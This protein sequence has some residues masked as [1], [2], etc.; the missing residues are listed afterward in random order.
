MEP[1]RDQDLGRDNF[2]DN[3]IP[4][5]WQRDSQKDLR[6]GAYDKAPLNEDSHSRHDEDNEDEELEEDITGPG[7]LPFRSRR[8]DLV[9]E[10]TEFADPL[11]SPPPAPS[12]AAF[13]YDA[14]SLPATVSD[15]RGFGAQPSPLS[16]KDTERLIIQN[17]PKFKLWT[18]RIL[19]K[20]SLLLFAAVFLLLLLVTGLV[21]HLSLRSKGLAVANEASHYLG[22]CLP[23]TLFVF[24][25]VCWRQVDY[26]IKSLMPWSEMS[27]FP[28][29]AERSVF[30]DYLTPALPVSF[31]RA[32][33]N[34]HWPVVL[35]SL[36][37]T[38]L[39]GTMLFSTGL[40][41]LEDA[42]VSEIRN[43]I[44]L[45]SEFKLAS[46][47]DS[48]FWNVGPGGAQLYNAVNF[49]GLHYPPGTSKDAL[50]PQLQIPANSAGNTNFSVS[51][52]AMMFDLDCQQLPITN[53]T[54]T[55]I[56]WKSMLAQY[57]VADVN[58]TDCSIKGIPLAG[59]PD[60]YQY[61]DKNAT[62]NYQ[63]Q[64]EVYPCNTGWDF[65][66]AEAKPDDDKAAIVFDPSADQRVFLSVTNLEISP[67]DKS[68]NAPSYM[69][70]NEISAF[71]CKPSYTMRPV[72]ASQPSPVDGA[73][74]FRSM[75]ESGSAPVARI[76]T[77]ADNERVEGISNGAVAMAVHASASSMFLGTGGKDFAL[78]EMVPTFFQFM[79][80]KAKKDGIGA[81]TDPELLKATAKNVYQGMA[82]QTMHLLARQ[83]A[84]K[85]T[86]G[87]IEYAGQKLVAYLVSTA[88]I[89][90][91]LGMCA[92]MAAILAFIA[93][94]AV[95]PSR[96]GSIASMTN[97]MATSPLFRQVML[98]TGKASTSALRQ[99]LEECRYKTVLTSTPSSF[100]LEAVRQMETETVRNDRKA[101]S[102]AAWWRP[103]AAHWWFLVLA[104]AIPLAMIG[105]LEGIQR[106][107]DSNQGFLSVSRSSA[108][109]FTTFIPAAAVVCIASTYAK[110]STMAAVFAPFLALKK[111]HA[112]A[113]RTMHFDVVGRTHPVAFLR[114]IKARHFAV[115]ILAA[116]SMI[117]LL[118]AIVVSSLYSVVE[119]DRS[120]SM[121]I[122]RIDNFKLDNA[123]LTMQDNHAASMDS[124]IRYAGVNYSQ[125]TWE[126]LAFP[127]Y[128]QKQF[129]SD[130]FLGDAPL[131]AKVQAI[132]PRLTCSAV[133]STGRVISQVADKQSPGAYVKLP[134]QNEYW[135]PRPGHVTV[136]FNTTLKFADYCETPP[137]TNVSQ[138]SWMQ[139]F[140]VPNDTNTAYIGKGSVLVWDGK[141]IY[142]DGAV[143]THL[144]SHV[145]VNF[146][147]QDHGCPSFAATFGTIKTV[148]SGQG[149]D[150]S[151]WKFE[152]DLATVICYQ[153][154]EE[155]T[156]DVTWQ[157]PDL[158]L[159]PSHPPIIDESSARKLNSSTGSERFQ[160]PVNAWLEGL[161]DPVYDRRIPA[162]NNGT[163]ALNDVDELIDALILGQPGVPITDIVGE[164]NARRLG[165]VL[166][167]AYQAYMAQA[168]S[169]NMRSSTES[170]S[171]RAVTGSI[172]GTMRIPDQRR[173]VQNAAPKIALQVL[174]AIMVLCLAAARP[175]LRV[176]RV[177]PHNPRTIAG[178][179]ALLADSDLAT[180]KVIPAGSEWLG[181]DALHSAKVLSGWTFALRWWEDAEKTAEARRYGVGIEMDLS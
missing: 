143:N 122:Q 47:A 51:V 153:T 56:S 11:A 177:L 108:T 37:Y 96:P 107:S 140:S 114:S 130:Q 4:S 165:D 71:L 181:D 85:S 79:T 33:R 23:T 81:F 73:A 28:A 70:V 38:L 141:E 57:F 131:V 19:T 138:A 102:T 150:V 21:Y 148:Q 78:S 161:T 29:L 123:K 133:P 69:Y 104:L 9:P 31:Y 99:K 157:L 159:D 101:R 42:S 68:L 106:L 30:V 132:R 80:M 166:T 17:G 13:H 125:W 74:Q 72:L 180:D 49:Q 24:I 156:A 126:G 151:S 116:A 88:M 10:E 2:H 144:S 53:A 179:A 89:C 5:S 18:P 34:R 75:A 26:H 152:H 160:I 103:T 168:V 35:S 135:T 63:A 154:F 8:Y 145:S 76:E 1:T 163:S 176:G 117:A 50:I 109:I 86:V 142:G 98:G 127:R 60:H 136:G 118:L 77:G 105:A 155:V 59:G 15:R 61:N 164:S 110:L 52:D 170:I 36:V 173:L 45:K 97:I 54:K 82:A 178:M 115:A 146:D 128:E 55:S 134:Y 90:T 167:R 27:R 67:Y 62:Q 113:H 87:S 41:M 32:V 139:Y 20:L 3:L 44:K 91:F 129:P 100:S 65:S 119:F 112:A 84:E 162:P 158:T 66:K 147:V 111:G 64:F 14:D 12:T 83:R 22:R 121:T 16:P 39:I 175:L 174:L 137:T 172:T 46:S 169:L 120:E 25:S 48:K 94:R 92:I 7:N 124:L 6:R 149:G 43:D 58:T 40:L 95:T 171:P 93:P